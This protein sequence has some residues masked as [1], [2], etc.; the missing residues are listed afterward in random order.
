MLP[1][2]VLIDVFSQLSNLDEVF[3][4][5]LSCQRLWCVWSENTGQIYAH[6]G[7]K[8]IECERHARTFY[9]IQIGMKSKLDLHK[10][11][12]KDVSRLVRNVKA[13]TNAIRTFET[14]V[15]PHVKGKSILLNI[16]QTRL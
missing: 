2:E 6:V 4:L 10:V 11:S 14:N 8:H 7:P 3:A 9:E 15:V 16:C 1:T 12:V 13:I 5:A